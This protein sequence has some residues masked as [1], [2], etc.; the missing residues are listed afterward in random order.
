MFFPEVP[1]EKLGVG[2]DGLVGMICI[3][4][5]DLLGAGLESSAVYQ[6]VISALKEPFSFRE[7]KLALTLSYDQ[8]R[9]CCSQP[10]AWPIP[11][12]PQAYDAGKACGP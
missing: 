8:A 2:E 3:H 9:W 4:V 10:Q 12:A 1:H 11:P 5:D 7:W 6:H